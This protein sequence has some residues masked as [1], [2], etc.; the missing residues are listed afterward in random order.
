LGFAGCVSPIQ[1]Q[2]CIQPAEEST[3]GLLS[4][5]G[6]RQAKAIPL[7]ASG[8]CLLQYYAEG[9]K[10]KENFP[11]KIWVNP[12]NQIRVQA[13]VFFDARGIDLGSNG[14]QFW[15]AIKPRDISTYRWGNWAEQDSFEDLAI[16][17]KLVLEAL[18]IVEVDDE[19][20]WSFSKEW[21]FDVLTKRLKGRII[22]KIYVSNSD[23]RVRKIE[24]FDTK[25]RAVFVA[26]L[27]KYKQVADG[28]DVATVLKIS[29]C[30]TADREDSVKITLG[31]VKAAG[32]N[33]RQKGLLFSRPEPR[34]FRSVYKIVDGEMSEQRQ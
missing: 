24:Y 6:A 15:F 22:K 31:S 4:V 9:R 28:L 21:A 14:R 10:N 11:V 18:G 34:G 30:L 27:D 7:R 29:G 12:P 25:G 5:L 1:E 13:D 23:Y 19:Q 8:Q 17:P 16:G 32:F 33:D 26:E 2:R 20:N 3:A